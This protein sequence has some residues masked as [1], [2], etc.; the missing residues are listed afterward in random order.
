[1]VGYFPPSFRHYQN[2]DLP[3]KMMDYVANCVK[4]LRTL[5]QFAIFSLAAFSTACLNIPVI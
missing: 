4:F 1:M 5:S 3:L 2:S